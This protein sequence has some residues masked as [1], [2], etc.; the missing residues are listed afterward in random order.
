MTCKS[1]LLVCILAFL[2]GWAYA[3]PSQERL[4]A[5]VQENPWLTVAE[6]ETLA[7]N[8]H[9]YSRFGFYCVSANESRAVGMALAVAGSEERLAH[10]LELKAAAAFGKVLPFWREEWDK[11]ENSL[12]SGGRFPALR[13]R[14]VFYG[15]VMPQGTQC[16]MLQNADGSFLITLRLPIEKVRPDR[17]RYAV[18]ARALYA[19]ALTEDYGQCWQA[20]SL[21]QCCALETALRKLQKGSANDSLHD[22]L[23]ALQTGDDLAAATLLPEVQEMFPQFPPKIQEALLRRIATSSRPEDRKKLETKKEEE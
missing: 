15:K 21:E 12:G 13:E 1:T 8:C 6:K 16:E 20:G 11:L 14:S 2:N 18:E 4:L 9:A 23:E 17:E 7:R 5:C 10:V 19:H 3:A 22:Y